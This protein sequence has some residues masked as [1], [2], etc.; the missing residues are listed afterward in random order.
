MKS[1]N[2]F[3]ALVVGMNANQVISDQAGYLRCN[4]Q[5]FMLFMIA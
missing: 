4:V 5:I 2:N 1:F 3:Q